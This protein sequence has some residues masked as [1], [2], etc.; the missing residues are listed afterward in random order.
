[1][2]KEALKLAIEGR[3]VVVVG[4]SCFHARALEQEAT[5][6]ADLNLRNPL[7]GGGG[8]AF[9][10]RDSDWEIDWQ[11][12]RMRRTP[13]DAVL[14]VDHFALEKEICA[15]DAQIKSLERIRS[16]MIGHYT[17]FDA[18]NPPAFRG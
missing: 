9:V 4:D 16:K 17:K 10:G 2:L 15:V 11:E 14:L 12:W 3:F 18:P 8:V 1:M 13:R 6:M 7:P 5:R